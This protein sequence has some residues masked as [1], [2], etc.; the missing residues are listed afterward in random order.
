MHRPVQTHQ[1]ETLLL[2]LPQVIQGAN[3][4]IHL[5]RPW[6]VVVCGKPNVGKSSLMN[7]IVG[8]NRAIVH[9]QPGTTCDVV[10]QT[11]AVEGWPIELKDTAGLRNAENPIEAIGV[12]LSREEI[13]SGLSWPFLMRPGTG[14]AKIMNCWKNRVPRWQSSTSGMPWKLNLNLPTWRPSACKR[15]PKR[16]LEFRCLWNPSPRKSRVICPPEIC[17]FQS[18]PSK[19]NVF[20]R[21]WNLFEQINSCRQ[22]NFGNRMRNIFIRTGN[23]PEAWTDYRFQVFHFG[24]PSADCDRPH[25]MPAFG[26]LQQMPSFD[27]QILVDQGRSQLLGKHVKCQDALMFEVRDHLVPPTQN[28]HRRSASINRRRIGGSNF[29]HCRKHSPVPTERPAASRHPVSAPK[30]WRIWC[31]L[32]SSITLVTNTTSDRFLQWL[33]R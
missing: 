22:S 14:R 3:F 9:A 32:I 15:P 29:I 30:Y 8:F 11:T 18:T 26:R 1:K 24:V 2:E 7:A 33:R 20:D 21:S 13:R 25:G 5:T 16:G 17:Y 27:F 31:A 19:R 12:R 23:R 6:S 4:G 28:V 10:T